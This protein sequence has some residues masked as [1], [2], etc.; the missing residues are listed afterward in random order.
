MDICCHQR[1]C[2]CVAGPLGVCLSIPE[3]PHVIALREHCC[4]KLVP[5]FAR[6][7][8]VYPQFSQN[9]RIRFKTKFSLFN[10]ICFWICFS[11]SLVMVIFFLWHLL[12]LSLKF[13]YT[14]CSKWKTAYKNWKILAQ[15]LCIGTSSISYARNSAF[16]WFQDNH[17]CFVDKNYPLL[18]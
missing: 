1:N 4:W 16:Q 14:K 6:C 12:I 8:F 9:L 10:G 3:T 5:I 17:E 18:C 7:M 13:C 11:T 15:V 2:K